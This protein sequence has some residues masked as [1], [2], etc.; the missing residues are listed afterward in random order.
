MIA[1][2][3]SCDPFLLIAD[4]PTTGLDV[5]IQAQLLE[6]VSSLARESRTS[7]LWITHDLGVV[8]GLCDQVNV[9]YAGR[10]VESGRVDDV[11]DR[12]RMPYTM[13]LLRSVP[14]LDWPRRGRLEA[15][16]GSPPSLLDGD[17]P[18]C[19]FSPRCP[20]RRDKCSQEEPGLSSR[21]GRG[22]LARCWGTERGAWIVG[23]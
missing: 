15:I 12:S 16:S 22:H 13:G 8:A 5:T 11:F 9:M 18:G 2:A 21:E 20:D 3:L 10:I 4:E 17:L 14:R 19:R 1:I 7:V 23:V 6:L